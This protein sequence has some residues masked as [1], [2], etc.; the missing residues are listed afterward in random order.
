MDKLNI[1]ERILS[2]KLQKDYFRFSSAHFI[3]KD[4][5]RETLHGHNYRLTMSLKG[6]NIENG[7]IVDFRDLKPYIKDLCNKLHGKTILP[8]LCPLIEIKEEDDHTILDIPK[9]NVHYVLPTAD[10]HY[11]Q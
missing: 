3:C 10:I 5:E 4:C 11:I 1:K 7:M 9:Y 2:L 8:T 6:R